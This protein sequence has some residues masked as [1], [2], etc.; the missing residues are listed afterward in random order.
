MGIKHIVS[1]ILTFVFVIG[2]TVGFNVSATAGLA[3]PPLLPKC[4]PWDV[5]VVMGQC[6]PAPNNGLGVYSASGCLYEDNIGCS[7]MGLPPGGGNPYGCTLWC[8][9]AQ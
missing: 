2:I 5:E 7:C 6:C 4:A 8:G 1:L 3:D 9:Q